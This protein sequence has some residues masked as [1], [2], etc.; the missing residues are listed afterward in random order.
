MK[1]FSLIALLALA[2]SSL[3]AP[4]EGHQHHHHQ[5][6]RAVVTQV[7]YVDSQG[8]QVTPSQSAASSAG[9]ASSTLT[10]VTSSATAAASSSSASSSS[11]S[12]T[13]GSSTSSSSSSSSSGSGSSGSGS[14]S[15]D[16]SA[17]EDPSE[18]FEDG[19]YDCDTLP[20]GQGVIAIDWIS[21][22][23]GGWA[24]V[25]NEDG[26]TSS[27][28]KDGYYCSYACQA[29]MSKTQWPSEQPSSGI[30]VGGL[31]CKNGKL[32]KSNSDSDY[33]CAWGKD[34]AEFKSN[35]KKDVAICRTDYPG[36]E[37]MNIPTLLEAGSTAPVSVVDSSKY[38]TWK[39]GKTSTQYYVNNAGVSVEDGC[40]WGTDG[41][42]VGNWAPV[43]LG[44]GITDGKTYL[45][46]IPNPNNKDTPNYNIKIKGTNGASINGDCSYEDGQ[47]NGHGTDGCTSTLS[48]GKAQ[49]VF[50]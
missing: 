15:G 4:L 35:I 20:T 27:T 42:G 30:S 29:G 50:Y 26:E 5:D 28:C 16:L 25:M 37:N 49:F 46:L 7:V 14:I 9:G 43:V 10:S 8:K 41:S 39:S 32:Y 47:Y 48:S 31:Q 6:K 1:S 38:Y 45:S 18:T 34:T 12:S 17:Y 11:S 2:T 40:I 33:L 19:K 36:S 21:G 23:K 22:T 3:A 13:S 44:A 24:S